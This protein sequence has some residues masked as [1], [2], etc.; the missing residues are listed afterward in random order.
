[1]RR[2]VGI[3]FLA[4]AF[5][6]AGPQHSDGYDS[7][8]ARVTIQSSVRIAAYCDGEPAAVGSGVA[9]S[10]RHVLTA[11]HVARL[12]FDL[13]NH[14]S[15]CKSGIIT[16][17]ALTYDGREVPMVEE[18]I[19]DR[20]DA[21]TLVVSGAGE[22]FGAY[23]ERAP[24]K[25]GATVCS[26]TAGAPENWLAAGLNPDHPSEWWEEP[27]AFKCGEVGPVRPGEVE[28]YVA[29]INSRGGN[30]GSGIFDARGRV[31]GIVSNGLDPYSGLEP[32][33]R[34]P[35]AADLGD[36][37]PEYMATDLLD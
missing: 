19:S 31:V 14:L 2:C 24:V 27:F 8:G 30:S 35:L 1:M 9:I 25:A 4:A 12:E 23:A 3:L 29:E 15:I 22:P 28:G 11:R 20:Y 26:Y 6:C 16:F 34:G 21:A 18:K 5:A 7:D 10:P 36:L 13:E 33:M 32:W 37:W 17:I